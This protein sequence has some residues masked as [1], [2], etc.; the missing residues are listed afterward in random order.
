MSN[1][2]KMKLYLIIE[3]ESA[4]NLF[5]VGPND[6]LNYFLPEKFNVKSND[7]V[8]IRFECPSDEEGKIIVHKDNYYKH[9][10]K[11]VRSHE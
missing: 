1:T 3:G 5:A 4:E 9:E 7:V 11:K 8:Q 10:I 6:L 2:D